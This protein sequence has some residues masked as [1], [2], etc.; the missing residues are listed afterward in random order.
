MYS[1]RLFITPWG[2]SLVFF[3]LLCVVAIFNGVVSL[4]KDFT[5]SPDLCSVHPPVPLKVEGS[6]PLKGQVSFRFSRIYEAKEWSEDGGGSGSGSTMGATATARA[7][8][9]MLVH[10]H[11]ITSML[12]APCG[13]S[14]WLPPLLSRLRKTVPCFQYHGVDVVDSVVEASKAKYAQDALT[15]FQRMDLSVPGAG[16]ALSRLHK[17]GFD[18]VLCRDALQHLP[19]LL[20]VGVLENLAATGA[21]LVAVGSYLAPRENLNRDI[22]IGDYYLI[23]LLK[24]PFNLS[25][26]EAV[27]VL[28][29]ESRNKSERKYLLLWTVEYLRG[30]DFGEMRRRVQKF[31]DEKSKNTVSLNPHVKTSSPGGSIQYL[32]RDK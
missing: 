12:D 10:R 15:T 28:N 20:A 6:A 2:V 19:M 11:R 26:A 24:E 14:Y 32:Q 16:L 9:E 7:L 22:S 30:V 31:I 3:S 13:S 1:R 25:E 27:D 18:L 21:K 4:H 5:L 23:N 29:E 17:A 8:L